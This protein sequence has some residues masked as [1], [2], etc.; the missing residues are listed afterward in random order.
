M[1]CVRVNKNNEI[2]YKKN[3]NSLKSKNPYKSTLI[4]YL[5]KKGRILEIKYWTFFNFV[6]EIYKIVLEKIKILINYGWQR[7]RKIWSCNRKG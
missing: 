3:S 4:W 1:I 2:Y 5:R 7:K 6:L